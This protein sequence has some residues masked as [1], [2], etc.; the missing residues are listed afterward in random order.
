MSSGEDA[1]C[2]HCF[3]RGYDTVG[4]VQ[5]PSCYC[6][7]G[8]LLAGDGFRHQGIPLCDAVTVCFCPPSLE[9]PLVG[10]MWVK[11]ETADCQ[12]VKPQKGGVAAAAGVISQILFCSWEHPLLV[13]YIELASYSLVKEGIWYQ[14]FS[15]YFDNWHLRGVISIPVPW[16]LHPQSGKVK[17]CVLLSPH[18]CGWVKSKQAWLYDGSQHLHS[19]RGITPEGGVTNI[20]KSWTRG[21]ETPERPSDHWGIWFLYLWDEE[22]PRFLFWDWKVGLCYFRR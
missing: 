21:Q 16:L 18:S 10:W 14:L 12:W 19:M 13:N 3:N 22:F 20:W 17:C 5:L 1:E 11:D 8:R 9:I 2:V 6:A 4:S 7:G 15:L